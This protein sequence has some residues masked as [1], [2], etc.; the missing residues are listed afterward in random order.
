MPTVIPNKDPSRPGVGVGKD[1]SNFV[2][3]VNIIFS[4]SARTS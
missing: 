2:L 4:Y 1:E 3:R